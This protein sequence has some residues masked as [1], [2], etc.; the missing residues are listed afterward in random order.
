MR[1]VALILI[2]GLTGCATTLPYPTTTLDPAFEDGPSRPARVVVLPA[3]V[4]VTVWNERGVLAIAS[5]QASQRAAAILSDVSA[6]MLGRQGYEIVGHMNWDGT[7]QLGDGRIVPVLAPEEVAQLYAAVSQ[8]EPPPEP[9]LARVRAAVSA[10]ALFAAQAA[11]D[12]APSGSTA[13]TVG[14]VLAVVLVVA[15]VAAV[16]I[17]AHHGGGHLGGAGH[18]HGG[19]GYTPTHIAL[20]GQGKAVPV[21][22]G[23]PVLYRVPPTHVHGP[24]CNLPLDI[25]DGFFYDAPAS[26]G[27]PED[28]SLGGAFR[29]VDL[30]TGRMLWS[31]ELTAQASPTNEDVLAATAARLCS[32]LPPRS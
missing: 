27:V 10:D 8:D 14:T 29:M 18:S 15:I 13:R 11:G 30:G 5:Q 17:A 4:A 26:V 1:R 21:R 31:S 25:H 16:A 19:G 28:D 12:K 32:T 9:V 20:P 23:R 7:C 3:S 6:D 24:S 2:L 22:L